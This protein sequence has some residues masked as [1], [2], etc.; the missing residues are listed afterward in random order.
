MNG[1]LEYEGKERLRGFS[2]LD[3]DFYLM[4][5]DMCND[6]RAELGVK[7]ICESARTVFKFV[8]GLWP[9]GSAK[10]RPA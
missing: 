10:L 9:P 1:P 6:D 7:R 5:G 2:I 8:S 4:A 3:N